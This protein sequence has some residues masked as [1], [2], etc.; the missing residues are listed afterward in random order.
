MLPS[1][2]LAPVLLFAA[3]AAPAAPATDVLHWWT[4]PGETAAKHA[5]ADAYRAAGGH[6]RDLAVTASEQARAAQALADRN[7][8]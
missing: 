6:W 5:L 3:C 4:S 8:G 7:P 2:M 1:R